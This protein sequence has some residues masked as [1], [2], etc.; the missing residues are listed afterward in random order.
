MGTIITFPAERCT[1]G[2]G[3]TDARA[4]S[5]SVIILPV[6][7]VERYSEDSDGREPSTS[8]PRGRRRKR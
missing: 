8:S 2:S 1:A 3:L 5:G 7:R 4:D 6:I